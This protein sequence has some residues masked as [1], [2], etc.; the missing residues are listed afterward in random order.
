MSGKILY[1]GVMAGD[2]HPLASSAV[3]RPKSRPP[4]ASGDEMLDPRIQVT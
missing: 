4:S 2:S 3:E 1:R